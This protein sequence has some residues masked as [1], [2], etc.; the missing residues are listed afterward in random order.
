METQLPIQ[1][2]IP[3]DT[4]VLQKLIRDEVDR[5]NQYLSFAQGQARADREYFKHLLDR[6][7]WVIGSIF[8]VAGT[9]T[10][11]LGFRSFE[12]LKEEITT[13]TKTEMQKAQ[14][15]SKRELDNVRVEVRKRVK[16]EFRSENIT[17]LVQKTAQERM[18]K[19]VNSIIHSEAVDA[20]IK[21]TQNQFH[22]LLEG[23]VQHEFERAARLND[24]HEVILTAKS[25]NRKAF[26]NL[27]SESSFAHPYYEIADS[28]ARE[29]LRELGNQPQDLSCSV[30]VQ[31]N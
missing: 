24:L 17:T 10:G 27:I 1:Q 7:L 25:G 19:E 14:T 2:P 3:L 8:L 23:P 18:G 11:V 16:S 28:T 15:E 5:S 4:D 30:K 29:I 6:F 22:N 21:A 26:D 13:V 12:Q 20:A 31:R 9:I